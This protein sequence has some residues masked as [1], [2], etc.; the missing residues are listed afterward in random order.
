[1]EQQWKFSNGEEND[2]TTLIENNDQSK[3]NLELVMALLV[4]IFL[5]FEALALTPYSLI[6]PSHPY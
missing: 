1:M 6:N 3:K 4:C 2:S 5:I